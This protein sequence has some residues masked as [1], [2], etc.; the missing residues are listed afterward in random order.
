MKDT[1]GFFVTEALALVDLSE[2]EA[3]AML[4]YD[5][6]RDMQARAF[7]KHT[8]LPVAPDVESAFLRQWIVRETLAAVGQE[9]RYDDVYRHALI[10]YRNLRNGYVKA[11]PIVEPRSHAG[12]SAEDR[13]DI[14]YDLQREAG[15][16]WDDLEDKALW[17]KP[18][19]AVAA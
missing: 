17:A 3:Q 16:R 9:D 2:D 18:A 14:A 12:L 11:D 13:A 1:V 5:L 6:V 19:A 8:V 15:G 7:L 4:G 10:A